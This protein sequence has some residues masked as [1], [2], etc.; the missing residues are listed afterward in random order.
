MRIRGWKIW[1]INDTRH[2]CH[3]YTIFSIQWE[4]E[5]ENIQVA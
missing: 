2:T 3:C 4:I 1:T 5:T